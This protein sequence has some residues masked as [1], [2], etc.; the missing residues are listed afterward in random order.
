MPDE[1][2]VASAQPGDQPP[3]SP[4]KEKPPAIEDKPF[5]EFVEQHYLPAL[6]KALE[7]QGLQD[8]E[9]SFVHQS[10]PTA[11]SLCWQVCG[12]WSRGRRSFLVAFPQE[13]IVGTK[14]FACADGGTIPASLEPFLGDER[15]ITLDLLVF[16]VVQRLNGQK[17]LGWN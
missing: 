17:W 9:L 13:K 15:K 7:A 16:G 12:K 8:L 6:K 5:F 4:K 3:A 11:K 2:T 14:A 1:N 10:L